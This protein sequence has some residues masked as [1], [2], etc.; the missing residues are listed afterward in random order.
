LRQYPLTRYGKK[1]ARQHCSCEICF[2][3]PLA[4]KAVRLKATGAVIARATASPELVTRFEQSWTD[5]L[6][7]MT[8]FFV[9][10]IAQAELV[11]SPA[12][13]Y[14]HDAGRARWHQQG[15]DG[16]AVGVDLIT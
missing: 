16:G 2:L 4:R 1:P 10:D 6:P 5:Y 12:Y 7:H 11:L 3:D 9:F 15:E 14:G 13:D 8:G